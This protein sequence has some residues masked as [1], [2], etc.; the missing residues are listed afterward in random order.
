MAVVPSGTTP[1]K[2]A[3]YCNGTNILTR[4]APT[5]Q[6]TV[7][8]ETI[9]ITANGHNAASTMSFTHTDPTK[10][11]A[12]PGGA[13][14]KFVDF[15]MPAPGEAMFGGTIT[16]RRPVPQ[17]AQQG[18]D[19]AVTAQDWSANLDRYPASFDLAPSGTT[20]A[21]I[22]GNASRLLPFD[23][24]LSLTDTTTIGTQPAWNWVSI[25]TVIE[26]CI[27]LASGVNG[28]P[29]AYYVDALKTLRVFRESAYSIANVAN[30]SDVTPTPAGS[31]PC[32]NLELEYDETGIINYC[33][34][35]AADFKTTVL[36]SYGAAPGAGANY[37]DTASQLQYGLRKA[38]IDQPR[39]TSGT[40][41]YR[42]AK[43]Y[44]LAHKDP[45]MR[46]SFDVEGDKCYSI[47]SPHHWAPE[48]NITI[49]NAA[50]GLSAAAFRTSS[51]TT[52]WQGGSGIH[53]HHVTF[54]GLPP[55]ALGRIIK[56]VFHAG[57]GIHG[58]VG[59]PRH[60][61]SIQGTAT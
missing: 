47:A 5:A 27:A 45:I 7:P 49:T 4:T 51:V 57:H 50:L 10:A 28:A 29:S 31:M 54:G 36:D 53:N 1:P 3:L 23:L 56:G 9:A 52:T 16:S 48:M 19:T 42:Y 2:F 22:I 39:A 34:V 26:D 11:Y 21:A 12:I 33:R 40:L 13:A 38:I 43:S 24:L 46:G 59:L 35:R 37:G 60:A 17:A 61:M 55:S 44:V 18:R 58:T 15:L 30:I 32:S 14:L 20:V 6:N 41:A 8:L 25:R